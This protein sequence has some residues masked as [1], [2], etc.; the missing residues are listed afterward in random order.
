AARISRFRRPISVVSYPRP[1]RHPRR[2]PRRHCHVARLPALP[3]D[4]RHCLTPELR[5]A[6]EVDEEIVAELINALGK[7]APQVAEEEIQNAHEADTA[8]D[9]AVS[10][11]VGSARHVAEVAAKTAVAAV[12]E[13]AQSTASYAFSFNSLDSDS[14]PE[15]KD[16]AGRSPRNDSSPPASKSWDDFSVP[17]ASDTA[18]AVLQLQDADHLLPEVMEEVRRHSKYRNNKNDNNHNHNNNNNHSNKDNN[19]D[20]GIEAAPATGRAHSEWQHQLEDSTAGSVF[21]VSSFGTSQHGLPKEPFTEI[22]ETQRSRTSSIYSDNGSSRAESLARSPSPSQGIPSR[23]PSPTPSRGP[24]PQSR[25]G[26]PES[27]V[28][29]HVALR[30]TT[31]SRSTSPERG[32]REASNDPSGVVDDTV[33]EASF[34]DDFE[35]EDSGDERIP[36]ASS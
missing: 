25:S 13:L 28:E 26:S 4:Y 2:G 15:E 27:Q 32:G 33:S 24:S 18:F 6:D 35:D 12:V 23:S 3:E 36:I 30:S 7:E 17:P 8:A 19:N 10:G 5:E 20:D 34:P 22:A 29:G 9:A 31:R 14:A 16:L 1:P 21:G 11:E